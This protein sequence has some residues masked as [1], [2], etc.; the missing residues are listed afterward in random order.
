[1]DSGATVNVMVNVIRSDEFLENVTECTQ[2]IT[3]GNGEKV[4][5]LKQGDITLQEKNMGLK[6]T[7][8]AIICEEFRLN[9]LSTKKL[10][11]KG[12][13]V[14]LNSQKCYIECKHQG[15]ANTTKSDLTCGTDGMY[16]VIGTQVPLEMKAFPTGT[17]QQTVWQS[18]SNTE[19]FD[20]NGQT[21]H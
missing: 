11:Q 16:Y 15:S 20:I 17:E 19:N 10:L 6:I 18:S 4:H 5:A 1:V 7:I 2:T 13:A 21:K 3:V 14:T 8:Q 9:I 12:H